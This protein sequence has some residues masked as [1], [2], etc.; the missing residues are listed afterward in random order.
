LNQTLIGLGIG[1][2]LSLIAG[3]LVQHT[4]FQTSSF[5]PL[6]LLSVGG[7]LLVATLVAAALPARRAASISP[8]EALRT[9]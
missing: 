8:T 1:I 4:L 6:V 2:P 5:Q 7:L 3:R 9:Q